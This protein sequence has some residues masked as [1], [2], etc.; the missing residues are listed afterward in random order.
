MK[1]ENNINTWDYTKI[2]EYIPN[3]MKTLFFY[4]ISPL[5]IYM[6]CSLCDKQYINKHTCSVGI[7]N[8]CGLKFMHIKKHI[9][10]ILKFDNFMK[11]DIIEI[12]KEMATYGKVCDVCGTHHPKI[13]NVNGFRIFKDIDL[14]ADCY[15]IPE[16]K[17]EVLTLSQKMLDEDIRQG[18]TFCAMCY[19][20]IIDTHTRTIVRRFERDHLN[21]SEKIGSVGRMISKG[22]PWENILIES[23]KCRTLCVA[24]H[25]IVTYL[26]MKSGLMRIQKFD[27]REVSVEINNMAV[28][29]LNWNE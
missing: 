29:I 28:Q 2:F 11:Q 1:S 13:K 19:V 10:P 21:P 3:N 6:K 9:C 25:S 23:N 17:I 16:I 14:C 24:C 27:K 12:K 7:C 4:Q 8:I 20:T 22:E 15:D 5:L 18:R 26:E